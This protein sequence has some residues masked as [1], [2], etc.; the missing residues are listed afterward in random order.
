MFHLIHKIAFY[1]GFKKQSSIHW[2][3]V[4]IL[5][6]YRGGLLE[7]NNVTPEPYL[8]L[9]ISLELYGERKEFRELYKKLF[10]L[11]YIYCRSNLLGIIS[12][13]EY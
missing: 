3:V 4:E 6:E 13:Q 1:G 8:F 9:L 11:V 12:A 7:N 10:N 5:Y 2:A